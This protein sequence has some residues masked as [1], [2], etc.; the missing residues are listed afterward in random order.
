MSE[1]NGP[2]TAEKLR[3]VVSILLIFFMTT[4]ALSVLQT[5]DIKAEIRNSACQHAEEHK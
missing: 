4:A 1:F 3:E 2:A 5:Y